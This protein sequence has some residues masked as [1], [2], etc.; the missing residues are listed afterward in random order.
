[1]DKYS[2]MVGQRYKECKTIGTKCVLYLLWMDT[3][4]SWFICLICNGKWLCSHEAGNFT[5]LEHVA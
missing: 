1:M 4:V 5:E 3:E 2:V